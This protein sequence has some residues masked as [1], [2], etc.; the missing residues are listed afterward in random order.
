MRATVDPGPNR[1][2]GGHWR[3]GLPFP[4]LLRVTQRLFFRSVMIP[5]GTT[6]LTRMRW[7]PQGRGRKERIFMPLHTRPLGGRCYEEQACR[8]ATRHHKNKKKKTTMLFGNP[9][10]TT[11]PLPGADSMRATPAGCRRTCGGDWWRSLVIVVSGDHCPHQRRRSSRAACLT[12]APPPGPS[13]GQ[14]STQNC[15]ESKRTRDERRH[16]GKIEKNKIRQAA[17]R[18]T[19]KIATPARPRGRKARTRAIQT[20]TSRKPCR[21]TRNPDPTWSAKARRSA[22]T[23]APTRRR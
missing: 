17:D 9:C 8:T 5:A 3:P 19:R 2:R 14:S 15:R 12:R 10:L 22:R 13:A 16:K 11:I 7:R 1:V 20:Q 21:C 6:V 18:P 23:S 4:I